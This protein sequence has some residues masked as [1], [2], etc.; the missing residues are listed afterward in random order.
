LG[1]LPR[2]TCSGEWTT[3]N[4]KG[5]GWAPC[6]LKKGVASSVPLLP[7]RHG[8]RS[9]LAIR[10]R[11]WDIG[12]LPPPMPA[13]LSSFLVLTRRGAYSA[14][15]TNLGWPRAS[16]WAVT[17]ESRMPTLPGSPARAILTS[18]WAAARATKRRASID[19]DVWTT[20]PGPE[21]LETKTL[22]R[23]LVGVSRGTDTCS[24][25]SRG[26]GRDKKGRGVGGFGRHCAPQEHHAFL[27]PPRPS[28]RPPRDLP[29]LL[30]QY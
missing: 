6:M 1:S 3:R 21:G 10:P 24:A 8:H 26:R 25:A 14:R 15:R 19:A 2:H 12:R 17:W 18:G 29:C 4:G 27:V 28:G 23:G 20:D 9:A 7:L 16:Q 5:G 13:F 22:V 11:A 30:L